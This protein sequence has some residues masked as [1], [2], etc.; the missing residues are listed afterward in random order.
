[1]KRAP[2]AC[3]PWVLPRQLLLFPQTLS[4]SRP[5]TELA[6]P[7]RELTSSS[8]LADL[9]SVLNTCVNLSNSLGNLL[10]DSAGWYTT[11][12]YFAAGWCRTSVSLVLIVRLRLSQALEKQSMLSCLKV[13]VAVLSA[14]SSGNRKWRTVTSFALITTC[15]LRKLNRFPT[16]NHHRFFVDDIRQHGC[17]HHV[18]ECGGKDTSL[19]DSVSWLKMLQ[20]SLKLIKYSSKHGVVEL[21]R[22][23]HELI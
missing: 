21:T 16:R 17:E 5:K 12:V 3:K 11:R 19:L 4:R 15:S 23:A 22:H 10:F 20:T 6:L 14:Q 18:E 2:L 8:I 13:S 9:E 1:M 7:M